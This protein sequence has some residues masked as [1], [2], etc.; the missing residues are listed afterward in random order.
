M[1]AETVPWSCVTV[2]CVGA[3]RPFRRAS[4]EGENELG[5]ELHV[6]HPPGMVL[7]PF[8]EV[9]LAVLERLEPA[10]TTDDSHG[11]IVRNGL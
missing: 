9:T 8:D 7:G 11:G 3:D 5:R 1:A 6:V 2:F 4:G 10:V